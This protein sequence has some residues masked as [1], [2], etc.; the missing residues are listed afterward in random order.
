MFFIYQTKGWCVLTVN[1]YNK[2]SV[3]KC[4]KLNNLQGCYKKPNHVPSNTKY[5]MV[6]FFA[7]AL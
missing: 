6:S 4:G 2:N 7:A 3:L 1:N 5:T